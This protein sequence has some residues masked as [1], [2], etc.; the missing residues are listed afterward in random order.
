MLIPDAKENK[1]MKTLQQ[2][3]SS[4]FTKAPENWKQ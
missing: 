1:E 3:K 2:L 4:Y